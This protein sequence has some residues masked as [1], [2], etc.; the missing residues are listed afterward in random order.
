[1]YVSAVFRMGEISAFVNFTLDVSPRSSFMETAETLT[2][3]LVCFGMDLLDFNALAI[4]QNVDLKATKEFGMT[5]LRVPAYSPYAVAEFAVALLL[6]VYRRLVK[7]A[8]RTRDHDFSLHEGLIGHDVH[9][10]TVGVIGTGK[11]GRILCKIMRG[12]GCRVVAFDLYPNEETERLGVEYQ[13]LDDVL[14]NSD[15]LSLH[16]PLLDSTRHIIDAKAV[17]K[18]KRGVVI[19]NTSRGGLIET[20]VVIAGLKSGQIGGLGMDVYENEGV[21][22]FRDLSGQL[23][24]DD[25]FVQLQGMPNVLITPV[26]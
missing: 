16:C 5:V 8:S 25:E 1:M 12:F 4:I 13:S 10:K 6:G 21:M 19:V 17:A 23:I 2:K 22:Y 20:S 14:A 7:A 18:M 26:S 24:Q 9:G 15:I 3:P 11:I